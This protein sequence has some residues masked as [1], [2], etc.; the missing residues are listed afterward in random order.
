MPFIVPFKNFL[1]QRRLISNKTLSS[2]LFALMS[3]WDYWCWLLVHF[4]IQLLS[5]V[6]IKRII[7]LF[8]MMRS[9]LGYNSSMRRDSIFLSMEAFCTILINLILLMRLHQSFLNCLSV[10]CKPVFFKNDHFL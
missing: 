2:H 10:W 3:I 4:S 1:E 5:L 9:I 7:A 6:V 8:T